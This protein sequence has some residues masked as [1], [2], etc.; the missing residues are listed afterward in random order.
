MV[1][2]SQELLVVE[3]LKEEADRTDLGRNRLYGVIFAAGYNDDAR[4]R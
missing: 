3:G 4:L 2:G 1:H